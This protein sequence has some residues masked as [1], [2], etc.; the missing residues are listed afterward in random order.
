MANEGPKLRFPVEGKPCVWWD[1]PLVFDN[2]GTFTSGDAV[3]ITVSSDPSMTPASMQILFS[4]STMKDVTQCNINLIGQ[5]L[6]LS[7]DPSKPLKQWGSEGPLYIRAAIGSKVSN[8]VVTLDAHLY[9]IDAT[10]E[11]DSIPF[12]IKSKWHNDAVMYLEK[13]F[14]AYGMTIDL[15]DRIPN[16]DIVKA[17]DINDL[18]YILEQAASTPFV[19]LGFPVALNPISLWARNVMVGTFKHAKHWKELL[20][21]CQSYTAISKTV[22][23]QEPML[24][25]V[26]AGGLYSD[27]LQIKLQMDKAGVIYYTTDGSTPSPS[28]TKYTAPIGLSGNMVIK[29]IG[30]SDTGFYSNVIAESYTAVRPSTLTATNV[31]R[32]V[33]FNW[34]LVTGA[35]GYNL[36]EYGT[37]VK[38]NP[39]VI[40]GITYTHTDKSTAFQK[41]YYMRVVDALGNESL[42]SNTVDIMLGKPVTYWKYQTD[43]VVRGAYIEDIVGPEGKYPDNGKHT[44]GFWYVKAVVAPTG[45]TVSSITATSATLTWTPPEGT[46]TFQVQYGSSSLPVTGST[47]TITGLAPNTSYTFKVF[48]ARGDVLSRTSSDATEAT[49][50]NTPSLTA[51]KE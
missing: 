5:R 47:V 20:K 1:S 24:N 39:S 8:Y 9:N 16:K 7:I 48:G 31:E 33:T 14:S 49:Y 27:G 40:T 12:I 36:Y 34:S 35:A 3:E 43:G 42:P 50:A 30:V 17:G 22:S 23:I 29:A 37:N 21:Y 15:L 28:K 51:Y 46:N 4:M 19:T 25:A 38:I 13:L 10:T 26:P 6:F 32:V 45:V 2:L 11:F 18:R 44:D 41:T